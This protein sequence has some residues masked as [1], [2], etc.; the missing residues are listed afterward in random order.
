MSLRKKLRHLLR[1]FFK[2]KLLFAFFSLSLSLLL[3]VGST[4]AWITDSDQ[5]LNRSEK[6]TSK[7][8]VRLDGD[9]NQVMYWAPGTT[10]QKPIRVANYGKVPAMVRISFEEFFVGF[11]TDVQDNHGD[12]NGNGDLVVYASPELPAITRDTS[13]WVVGKTYEANANKYYKA[14]K[15][16]LNEAYA[17]KGTRAEPLPAVQLN[18][19]SNKF[20][21]STNQPGNTEKDYWYYEDGFFYYSEILE[22]NDTT[23]DL[24]ASVTLSSDYANQYKGGLY[25]LVPTMDAHD[26]GKS[27]LTNWTLDPSKFVHDMYKDKLH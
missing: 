20:F 26:I 1:I 23:T 16:L 11:E 25:H 2:S 5:R 12:G 10:K 3:V 7:L 19:I 27:L 8:Q 6:Q 18:F 14:N 17:Y 15:V 13:T 9:F 21:D 4:Y 24:L 22:P